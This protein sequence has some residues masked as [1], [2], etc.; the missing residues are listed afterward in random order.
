M[1]PTMG[2]NVR[3]MSSFAINCTMEYLECELHKQNIQI[4]RP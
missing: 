3:Q 4:E 2:K 1:V